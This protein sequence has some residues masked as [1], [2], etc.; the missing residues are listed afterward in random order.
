[1]TRTE[2]YNA[3]SAVCD[4]YY[5]RAPVGTAIPYIV[6][7]WTHPNNFPADDVVYERIA[8]IEIQCY[9]DTPETAEQINDAL[10]DL[11]VYWTSDGAFEVSDGAYLTTYT[12]EVLDN[13]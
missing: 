10:D 5:N 3:L 2:L 12:M 1:M 6:Y 8:S 9:S 7:N 13:E 4:T 11:G